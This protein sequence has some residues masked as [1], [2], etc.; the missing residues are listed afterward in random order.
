MKGSGR[1]RPVVEGELVVYELFFACYA[2]SVHAMC[3]CALASHSSGIVRHAGMQFVF[4]IS[5]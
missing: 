5:N 1:A 3:T 4:C 2:C